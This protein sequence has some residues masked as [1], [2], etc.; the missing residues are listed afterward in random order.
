M[1]NKII[2]FIYIFLNTLISFGFKIKEHLINSKKKKNIFFKKPNYLNIHKGK[3]FLIILSGPSVLENKKEL[4][5]LSERKEIITLTCNKSGNLLKSDYNIF[6]NR[7]RFLTSNINENKSKKILLSTMFNKN[8]YSKYIKNNYID[9]IPNDYIYIGKKR[10]CFIKKGVIYHCNAN[11]AIISI[12]TAINMGANNIYIAGMDGYVE[13]INNHF[14]IEK[15][16]TLKNIKETDINNLFFLEKISNNK[17][18]FKI[19]ELKI[20]TPTK[21]KGFYK[22]IF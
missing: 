12:L 17:I 5:K 4:I 8:L 11:V 14:Y 16:M 18:E 3:D 7:R 20:I 13:G 1:N 10:G 9:L 22:K 15:D 6:I 21:F 19:N 2:T